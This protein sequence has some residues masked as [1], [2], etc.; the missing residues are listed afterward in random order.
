MKT[1]AIDVE[2]WPK[3]FVELVE[4]FAEQLGRQVRHKPPAQPP[5]ERPRWPGVAVPPE[6]LRREEIYK[7][8][9]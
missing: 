8:V 1:R 7:D 4:R 2:G 9:R 5:P 3:T 6:V